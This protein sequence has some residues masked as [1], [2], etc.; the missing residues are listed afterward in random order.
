MPDGEAPWPG[1]QVQLA[2]HDVP[3][4]CEMIAYGLSKAT[5]LAYTLRKEA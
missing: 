1:A 3:Q 4:A 5:G 2:T